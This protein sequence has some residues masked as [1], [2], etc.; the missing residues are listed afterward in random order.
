MKQ[1]WSN[2]EIRVLRALYADYRGQEIADVL[3]RPISSVY[4]IAHLHD[5]RKSEEFNRSIYSGRLSC[6]THNLTPTQFK[7]GHEPFN[8]GKR[9]DEFMTPKGIESTKKTW[10]QKGH[11]P[12]N[13]LHDGEIR[14]RR[15]KSN[16]SYKFIRLSL[17]VWQA[18][19]VYNWE[20]EKGPVPEGFIVVF[21][22]SGRMNCEV[23][24]LELITRSEHMA[25][26]SIVRY[27]PE[28]RSTM[29]TLKKLTRTIN[30]KE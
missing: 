2:M 4:R 19:H 5:L 21:K 26:N 3:G 1:P 12:H 20:K 28:L 29:H 7:K 11:L 15:D 17:G 6:A 16:D 27:P 14:I 25:R 23:S 10:F 9:L 18:L 8:K 30:G 22:T 24:N 13:T